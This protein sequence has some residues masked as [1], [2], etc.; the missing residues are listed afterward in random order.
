MQLLEMELTPTTLLSL[1]LSEI[2]PS[3]STWEN[4]TFV[5]MM[6]RVMYHAVLRTFYI[7]QNGKFCSDTTYFDLLYA[8]VHQFSGKVDVL[9]YVYM[10]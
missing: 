5:E 7:S 6:A 9:A 2:M 10:R 4:P 3:N 8:R 1:T